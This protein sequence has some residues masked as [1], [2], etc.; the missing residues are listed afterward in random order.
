MSFT[1]LT[2]WVFLAF[3]LVTYWLLREQRWQNSLLCSPVICLWVGHTTACHDASISTLI[4]FFWRA[5]R[6]DRRTRLFMAL[7]LVLNWACWHWDFQF[8]R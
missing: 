4:D 3:V 1:T 7:S 6:Q 2:F 5:A 8:L